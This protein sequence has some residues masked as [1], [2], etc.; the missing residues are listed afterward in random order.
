MAITLNEREQ[1]LLQVAWQCMD[2][3]P[4]P[5]LARSTSATPYDYSNHST[6]DHT[7]TS[8]PQI[9]YDKLA[10]LSGLG[11]KGSATTAWCVLKKKLT[12]GGGGS[13]G[14]GA[15]SPATPKT[16][17][18]KAP[19]STRKK[20]GSETPTSAKRKVGHIEDY[21]DD[22]GDDDE[23]LGTSLMEKRGKKIRGAAVKSEGGIA[24][25]HFGDGLHGARGGGKAKGRGEKEMKQEVMEDD[26]GFLRGLLQAA[27]GSV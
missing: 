13:G 7:L 9:D 10:Q 4:K 22:D 6:H 24:A 18:R 3:Q 2:V 5:H 23:E 14:K 12:A 20:T 25:E 11:T 19:G 15:D 16:T 27:G 21:G 26:E 8:R 1:K 17:S